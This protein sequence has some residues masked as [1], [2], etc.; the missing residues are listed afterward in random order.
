MGHSSNA[1]ADVPAE[2]RTPSSIGSAE[3]SNTSIIYGDKLILK[4][5]R[6]LEPGENPDV[7]I[8]RFLTE[9]AQYPRIA[10]FFG[11][12]SLHPK[13]PRKDHSC[14]AA[15]SDHRIAEMGGSGFSSTLR[16]FWAGLRI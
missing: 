13:E 16:S 10:P 15:R 5:F 11:E 12:I 3:Q 6:R 9:V 7:E 8:G 4:F 1:L 14:D 2:G